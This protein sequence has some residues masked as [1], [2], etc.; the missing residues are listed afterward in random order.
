MVEGE[1]SATVE[2]LA[3]E[4]SEVVAAELSQAR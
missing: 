3:H 2:Q 4:L 1:D